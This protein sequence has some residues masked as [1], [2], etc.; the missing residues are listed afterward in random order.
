MDLRFRPHF[1]AAFTP[2]LYDRYQR[3]LER[4]LGASVA[5][6]LAETPVFLPAALRRRCAVAA[7][8]IISQLCDP[9]RIARMREAIP[10]NYRGADSDGLPQFL[11]LDFAVVRDADQTLN[12]R[13]IELQ[14]FPSLLAFETMQRDAW[15]ETMRDIPGLQEDWSCWYSGLGREGFLDL[16]R[17][18]IV[19]D[20]DP[21]HVV[22]LDLDP[23]T[24]KT[25][26]DF[27][28]TNKFFG[29]DAV[30]PSEFVQRGRRLYRR[31]SGNGGLIPIKR[32]YNRVIMDEVE[33]KQISLPFDLRDDLEVEW[34]PHPDWFFIWSKYSL[35]FLDHPA[36]PRTVLVSDVAA[37]PE[38][39][40]ERY[41]LKPL[42]SFAGG[43]VNVR[44]SAR[45][46]AAIPRAER[47]DWCLQEKVEYSRVLE[48][49]QGESAKV[50]L[51]MMFLRP[52]NEAR[53]IAAENLCRLSRGDMIGVD[54]N[55]AAGWVGS[56]VGIWPA[57]E[58]MD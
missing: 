18:A 10:E 38:S 49:T 46:L 32:I 20:H 35:P 54:F 34:A 3:S 9:A 21:K 11:I 58:V 48:T 57:G 5:F 30:D 28:A 7:T 42:F 13:L 55:T 52:D 53:F 2:A 26:A 8:E 31:A 51:R 4:R 1:N 12:P 6:R 24:Q 56:S 25:A 33:R 17:R 44:P 41:V 45:D 39:L 50:E 19:G 29:V 40:G 14:G 47:S 43:G 23:P 27:F 22:L 37:T 15:A 36:V 16:T